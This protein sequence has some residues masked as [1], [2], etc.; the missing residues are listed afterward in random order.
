[1][2]Y[3]EKLEPCRKNKGGGGGGKN[4]AYIFLMHNAPPLAICT[5]MQS[6]MIC[7]SVFKEGIY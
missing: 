2:H 4:R 3:G 1:M 5:I 6:S 7:N